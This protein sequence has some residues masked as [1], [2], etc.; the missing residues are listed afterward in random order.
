MGDNQSPCTLPDGSLA[1]YCSAGMDVRTCDDSMRELCIAAGGTMEVSDILDSCGGHT[2]SY[3]IHEIMDNS[4]KCRGGQIYESGH[5][6]LLGVGLDGYGIFGLYEDTGVEAVIDACGGHYGD[7][8][9][10]VSMQR[11]GYCVAGEVITNVY[12]YHFSEDKPHTLGC[13]GPVDESSAGLDECLALY[14]SCSDDGNNLYKV[15]VDSTELYQPY[16]PCYQHYGV[17]RDLSTIANVNVATLGVLVA[18]D[19]SVETI[20]R[21][22]AGVNPNG[23]C[24]NPAECAGTCTTTT[25]APWTAPETTTTVAPSVDCVGSW[26]SW[27]ACSATC[28]DGT[29]SR[30][31]SVTTSV[32]NGGAECNFADNAT[33]SQDCNDGACPVDCVGS[34]SSYSACSATC[35]DGTQSRVYSV[36]TSASNGGA[37]CNSVDNETQSQDCNDGA[38][39]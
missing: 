3:H 26:G 7:I 27:S 33:Q 38:C 21:S 28:G 20:E 8:P 37:E 36:T 18:L 22:V 4:N 35:G 14:D 31:Y 32:S 19:D 11:L 6:G 1:G 12:H 5:S 10:S 25:V 34:W 30:V 2:S 17:K 13:F 39:P 23:S 16:C 15:H 9:C 24:E 29:Q